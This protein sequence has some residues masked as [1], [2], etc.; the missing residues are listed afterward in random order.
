MWRATRSARFSSVPEALAFVDELQGARLALHA[1]EG[2][3][4]ALEAR[5]KRLSALAHP[6]QTLMTDAARTMADRPV[7]DLGWS[8][9]DAVCAR[10]RCSSEMAIAT[11]EPPLF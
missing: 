2:D 4:D 6:G 8:R 9:S 10:A 1:G 5:A 11:A 7:A 3:A